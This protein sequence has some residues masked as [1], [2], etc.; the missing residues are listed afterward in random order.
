MSVK[1]AKV[2]H[3]VHYVTQSR[4]KYQLLFLITLLAIPLDNPDFRRLKTVERRAG[5]DEDEVWVYLPTNLVIIHSNDTA[6][7]NK[8]RYRAIC[9]LTYFQIPDD[10][11]KVMHIKD[12]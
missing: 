8:T 3:S 2:S 1:N 11:G 5:M 10:W 4:N 9:D 6:F 12:G 7:L